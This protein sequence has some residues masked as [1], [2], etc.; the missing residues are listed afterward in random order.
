ME[1]WRDGEKKW[2]YGEKEERWRYKWRKGGGGKTGG[3]ERKMEINWRKI[4]IP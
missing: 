4:L 2:R 1:E 3:K